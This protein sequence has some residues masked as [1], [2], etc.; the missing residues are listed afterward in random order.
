MI[1]NRPVRTKSTVRYIDV[2]LVDRMIGFEFD[3]VYWHRKRKDIDIIRD[4]ELTKC[5][6]EMFHFCTLEGVDEELIKIRGCNL[7][8]C[9]I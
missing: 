1:F 8:S 9:I 5:G 3:G 6:W 4:D 2:A 7:Y